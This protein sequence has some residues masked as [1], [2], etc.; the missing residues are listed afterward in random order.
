[1]YEIKGNTKVKKINKSTRSDP[2]ITSWKKCTENNILPPLCSFE[3]CK[4]EAKNVAKIDDAVHV[5]IKTEDEKIKG[6][7]FI[8]PTCKGCSRSTTGIN[9]WKQVRQGTLAALEEEDNT[10][11]PHEDRIQEKQSP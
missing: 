8:I 3:D 6:N 9:E 11:E 5:T 1:M 2:W 10:E 4:K 7:L